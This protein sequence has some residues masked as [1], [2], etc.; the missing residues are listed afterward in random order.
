MKRSTY[1]NIL[2]FLHFTNNRNQ[3]DT[4]EENNDRL[5]KT[6]DVIEILNRTFSKSYNPSKNLATDELI[7][8][9]KSNF[10]TI[11]PQEAQMFWYQTMQ[12]SHMT[13]Y[14]Y[15][16]KAYLGRMDSAMHNS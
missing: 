16:M 11:Y 15:N 5:W 14:T 8:L 7:V 9:V 10:Q 4:T 2:R 13:G 12:I 1:S 6:W 3:A